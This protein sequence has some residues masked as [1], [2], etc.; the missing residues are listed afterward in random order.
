[1][2][3]K[4]FES[5]PIAKPTLPSENIY[6]ITSGGLFMMPNFKIYTYLDL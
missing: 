4:K 3:D 6:E 1:M 2:E 5:N